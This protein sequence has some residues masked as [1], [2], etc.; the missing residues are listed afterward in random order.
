M[1]ALRRR[2]KGQ[3]AVRLRPRA[4]GPPEKLF[5]DTPGPFEAPAA[6]FWTLL[7]AFEHR[8]GL[9]RGLL[10]IAVGFCV[11]PRAFGLPEELFPDTP[12]PLGFP[13]AAFWALLWAFA[14]RQGPRQSISIVRAIDFHCKKELSLISKPRT[15]Q[16]ACV[17]L[18]CCKR[19]TQAQ[20]SAFGNRFPWGRKPRL[21]R[22]WHFAAL[23][24]P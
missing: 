13:A 5:P 14:Y 7:R 16:K 4:F 19:L 11:S 3:R 15:I 24:C 20:A 23:P 1:P 2:E 12:G 18:T 10:C 9:L 22:F 21:L 6:A 8:R 17:N